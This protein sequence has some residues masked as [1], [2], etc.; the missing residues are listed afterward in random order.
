MCSSIIDEIPRK[1]NNVLRL[2]YVSDQMFKT[3]GLIDVNDKPMP[4]KKL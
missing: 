1:N 2:F 3:Y 4:S